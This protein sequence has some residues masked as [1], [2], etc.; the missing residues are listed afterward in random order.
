MRELSM[1]SIVSDATASREVQDAENPL[2]NA[3]HSTDRRQAEGRRATDRLPSRTD[4]M[5]SM[6]PSLPTIDL[7]APLAPVHLDTS[8][9]LALTRIGLS[10]G[11]ACAHMGR[12]D[13]SL[14]SRQLQSKDNAHVSLQRL[15]MLPQ[16]FWQEF[17]PT[18]AAA[19]GM[20]VVRDEPDDRALEHL[21]AVTNEA[22]RVLLDDRRRLR[23]AG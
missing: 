23:R 9:T 5:A 13:P 17:L 11:Q 6:S 8:I 7:N 2:S 3:L 10:H 15:L 4:R 16:A 12:L 18:L 21:V 20:R 1:S 19:A 14:W 22:F